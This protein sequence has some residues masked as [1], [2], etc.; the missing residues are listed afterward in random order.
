MKS[1]IGPYLSKLLKNVDEL[2]D[3]VCSYINFC[4]DLIALFKEISFY[5]NNKPRV[6][7]EIKEA[8]KN[9]LAFKSKNTGSNYY[10]HKRNS[11]YTVKKGKVWYTNKIEKRFES[12]NMRRVLD[13]MNLLS[14]CKGKGTTDLEGDRTYTNDL[15]KL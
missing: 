9:K 2:A 10:Q 4:V 15:N 1:P 14:G 6:P 7:R 8:I 3:I 13:S 11:K 12:N 5:P